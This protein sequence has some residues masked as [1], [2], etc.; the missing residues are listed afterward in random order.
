VRPKERKRVSSLSVVPGGTNQEIRT[1]A[2]RD[3][4]SSA[5]PGRRRL[6]GQ[7]PVSRTYRE[8][9][10]RGVLE[11]RDRWRLDVAL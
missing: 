10:S 1:S 8:T 2:D 7:R 4:L 3:L 5:P 11:E 6:R 9:Q